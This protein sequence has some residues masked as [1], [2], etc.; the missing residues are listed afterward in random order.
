MLPHPQS[1]GYSP[2]ALI[3]DFGIKTGGVEIGRGERGGSGVGDELDVSG[4][5]VGL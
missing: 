1:P 4:C 3:R 2:G 5:R